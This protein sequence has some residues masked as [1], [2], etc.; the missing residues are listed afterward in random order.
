MAYVFDFH[1]SAALNEWF[2]ASQNQFA[3]DLQNQ[4]ILDLLKPVSGEN[5]LDIG[6]GTGA[7]FIPFLEKGLDVTGLDPSPYMLDIAKKNF[8]DKIDLHRGYAEDLPFDDNS[9]NTAC[10]IT[11]LEFVED[12]VRAIEEACRVAKDR[13]FIGALNKYAIKGMQRRLEG[14]FRTS[15]YNRAKF[16]SV[17]ELKEYIYSIM[18]KVP[19]SWRTVCQFSNEPGWI[20]RTV[21]KST[22]I[23]N[24]PFGSFLGMAVIL[25]PHFTTW[26]LPLKLTPK[27]TGEAFACSVFANNNHKQD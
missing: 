5:I 8:E 24:F 26:T 4:L 11:T 3:I 27:Q 7:R 20:G 21:E 22:L 14:I 1:D 10:L 12:P 16:F 6:C 23:Q 17:W 25:V 2:Q 19:I 18:G 9:F 13:I 15:I